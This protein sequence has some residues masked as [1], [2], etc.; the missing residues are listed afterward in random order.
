MR[1]DPQVSNVLGKDNLDSTFDQRFS[2]HHG[3]VD[4]V[5][6]TPQDLDDAGITIDPESVD[7][8]SQLIVFT[9]SYGDDEGFN[10]ASNFLKGKKLA[11]PLL[12]GFSDSI[13]T[14]DSIIFTDLGM[15][16]TFYYL[17][18][19]NTYNDPNY[20]PDKLG[21]DDNVETINKNQPHLDERG[22]SVNYKQVDVGKVFKPRSS[23]DS[24]YNTLL[25][26][27]SD[28]EIASIFSDVQLEGRHN[29]SIQLGTRFV[30]PYTLIKNNHSRGN[31][32][33]VLGMLSFGTLLNYFPNRFSLIINENEEDEI[34]NGLSSDLEILKKQPETPEGEYKGFSIGYG[35]DV[36][37][38][39]NKPENVFNINFGEEASSPGQQTEFDQII[40]FSD[41][42]TFDAQDNDFTVSAFRNINFGA[43]GNF[44]I[45]NKGFSVI[46]SKNIYIGQH[47]KEKKEPMVL[48]DELRLLLLDVM[49]ILL[50]SRA[51]VQGVALPLVDKAPGTLMDIRINQMIKKLEDMRTTPENSF[52]SD[53]HYIEPNA[54]NP[55][56]S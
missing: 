48:G 55:N 20:S 22:Y 15:G 18:P 54:G 51:L 10:L 6:M 56:R 49:K 27:G 53:Y 13:A 8:V 40:M 34:K 26:E 30:N 42:I 11:Q 45:T 3:H 16:K 21:F 5:I 4:Q 35:N 9:P 31:N 33:S 19:I 17:G 25:G 52:L 2:F 7:S 23:L 47:A 28:A 1:T 38:D 36:G 12:R 24:A 50:D 46:E 29:N 14:G 43:V 41:R 44:T 32:G 37:P 39:E